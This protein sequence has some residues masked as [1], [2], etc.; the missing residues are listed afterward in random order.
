MS[1]HLQLGSKVLKLQFVQNA[2]RRPHKDLHGLCRLFTNLGTLPIDLLNQ[3]LRRTLEQIAELLVGKPKSIQQ[4]IQDSRIF[5]FSFTRLAG[6]QERATKG[7]TGQQKGFMDLHEDC[8]ANQSLH[9]LG[10]VPLLLVG[11]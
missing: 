4:T 5:R 6:Q 11:S 2:R 9:R 1:G 10:C 7:T 8:G 3:T